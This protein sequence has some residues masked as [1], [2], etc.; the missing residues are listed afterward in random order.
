MELFRNDYEEVL[1][2]MEATVNFGTLTE[3]SVP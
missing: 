3:P 1:G 2:P